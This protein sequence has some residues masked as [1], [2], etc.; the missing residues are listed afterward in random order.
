M[1]PS[2]DEAFK[3]INGQLSARQVN[4]T[5]TLPGESKDS[6]QNLRQTSLV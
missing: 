1:P 2:D 6:R 4:R 5:Q 3:T